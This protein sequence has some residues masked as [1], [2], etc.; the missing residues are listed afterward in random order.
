MNKIYYIGLDVHKDTIAIAHTFSG[1]RSEATYYGEC[2]GSNLALERAL[3]KLAKQLGVKLQ[4][5]KVCYEAGPTGGDW[6]SDL[7]A[8]R[9]LSDGEQQGYGFLLSWYETWRLGRRFLVGM[10][11][12]CSLV[13]SLVAG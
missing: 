9:D 10:S 3:R 1:S 2:G 12:H 11:F 7:M 13:N 8:A 5:F 6:R 4:D